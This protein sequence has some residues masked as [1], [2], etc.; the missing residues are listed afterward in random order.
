M[1]VQLTD[2]KG[3][4]PRGAPTSSHSGVA[5]VM[6]VSVVP[7]HELVLTD[8]VSGTYPYVVVRPADPERV[9]SI[10]VQRMWAEREKYKDE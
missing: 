10:A 8:G 7:G 4:W 5:N 1:Y 2:V 9:S 6:W 3:P